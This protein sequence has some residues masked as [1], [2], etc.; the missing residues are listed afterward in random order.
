[1]PTVNYAF[2]YKINQCL[3]LTP[4]EFRSIY[5]FGVDYKDQNGN[6]YSDENI[7]YHILNAQEE[8][9]DFLSIK[10]CPQVITET[11]NFS[12]RDFQNWSYIRTTFPVRKAFTLRGF[13]GEN[14]QQIDYPS[15]WLTTRRTNDPNM[16][17][18][19][20]VNIVPNGANSATFTSQATYTALYP[21]WGYTA[22]KIP[23]YWTFEYT[24]GYDSIPRDLLKAVAKLA[25][26]EYLGV[27]GESSPLGSGIAGKNISIDGLSQ[28]IQT[29]QSATSS[30]FGARIKQL[31]EELN[32]ELP[33][34]RDKYVG[35]AWSSL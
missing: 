11:F 27:I 31:T 15:E 22:T 32:K 13:V 3:A 7:E 20:A 4:A 24:T 10:L 14:N 33:L 28:G 12:I 8:I 5:S 17:Y 23:E 25:Q 19:R 30:I 34:L 18:E 26:I 35:V 1:M 16:G 9:E 29:T 2:P 21:F 6:S